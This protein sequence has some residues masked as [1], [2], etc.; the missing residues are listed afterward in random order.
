[1]TELL[2]KKEFYYET[3]FKDG[4]PISE[5]FQKDCYATFSCRHKFCREVCPTHSVDRDENHTSYGYQTMLFAVSEGM[6]TISNIK[7]EFTHC[8]QCGACETRCPTTLFSADFYKYETTT[9]DLVRKFRRDVIA[10]GETYFGFDKVQ[11][12]IDDHMNLYNGPA[13]EL[14]KWSKGLGVNII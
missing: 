8:L 11:K 13:D 10:S 3:S 14:L 9:V 5:E 7:D 12:Y 2:S 1:M 4:E 6:D